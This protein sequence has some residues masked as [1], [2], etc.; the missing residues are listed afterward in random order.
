[1]Q[2]RT[3]RSDANP[4]AFQ[5]LEHNKDT[6]LTAEEMAEGNTIIKTIID[7]DKKIFSKP[8]HL[9]HRT[10]TEKY[11][12]LFEQIYNKLNPKKETE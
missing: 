9:I 8:L 5:W 1:M 3:T 2:R 10:T 7:K 12:N 11:G 6:A 4:H